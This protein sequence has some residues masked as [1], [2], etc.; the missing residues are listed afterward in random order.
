MYP[1]CVPY[2]DLFLNFPGGEWRLFTKVGQKGWHSSWVSHYLSFVYLLW[3][4][5]CFRLL[6]FVFR[7]FLFQGLLIAISCRLFVTVSYLLKWTFLYVY[8]VFLEELSLTKNN[9]NDRDSVD[10]LDHNRIIEAFKRISMAWKLRNRLMC[11]VLRMSRE[12]DSISPFRI[13]GDF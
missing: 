10:F 7:F 9:S 8:V 3:M 6:M 2:S 12:K 1:R 11:E 5:L 4:G 13:I